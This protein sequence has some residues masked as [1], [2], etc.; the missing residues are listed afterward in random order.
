MDFLET[1]AIRKKFIPA[2]S[3]TRQIICIDLPGHGKSEGFSEVHS[4]KEM[5]ICVKAVIDELEIKQVSL[6]GH[7][8][9]GYVGLE[10]LKNFPMLLKSIVLINS[11]PLV[12][13]VERLQVRDR[14]I[15]LVAK[16]KNA[17]V[18]MAITNLFDSESRAKFQ[19]EIKE[20]K[21]NALKMSVKTIQ[22]SIKGMK[23]RTNLFSDLK[24]STSSKLIIAGTN[25]KLIE[26]SELERIS[27]ESNSTF[28]SLDGGH[29][30]PVENEV[31]IQNQLHL[32]D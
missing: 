27:R 11:T 17:F 23:I 22:A 32:I 7:S 25:D 4:M 18:S 19:S 26:T 16:N 12:D 6:A 20:L 3:A 31:G 1:S 2:L 24:N 15:E 13:S 28:I 30:L 10:L 8:M 5:A 21:Q 9:G 29:M 14:G